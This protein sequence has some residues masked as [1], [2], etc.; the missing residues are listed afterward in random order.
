MGEENTK[1]LQGYF[2]CTDWS[3]LIE[4]G[5]DITRNLDVFNSYF[6]FCFN[7]IAPSKEI[8]IFPNNKP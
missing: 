2:E 5:E 8:L 4:N 1:K 7:M 6:Y 3:L